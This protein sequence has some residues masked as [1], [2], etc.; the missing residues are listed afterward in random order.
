MTWYRQRLRGILGWRQCGIHRAG[1]STA[2]NTEYGQA[3][4]EW[5]PSHCDLCLYI[6]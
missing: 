4:G 6:V 5:L 1:P 3:R 2:G